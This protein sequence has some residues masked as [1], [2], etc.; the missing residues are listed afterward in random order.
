MRWLPMGLTLGLTAL[1]QAG[2]SP[3]PAEAPS[4]KLTPNVIEMGAFY[5]GKWTRIS[6]TVARGSQAIVVIR[7]PD[8]E[9]VFNRKARAGPIWI[10]SGRVHISGVPSLFLCYSSEPVDRL[11]QRDE[12]DENQLDDLAVKRQMSVTPKE[13]DHPVIRDNFVDLKI[14]E[15]VYRT[16]PGGLKMGAPEETG[17]PFSVDFHWPRKAP[18][19]RYQVRVY[20]CRDGVIVGKTSVRLDVVKIGF[21]KLMAYLATEHASSYG[22]VAVLLAVLGGLGIDFLAARLFRKR[23]LPPATALD[24][25]TQP[26]ETGKNRDAAPSARPKTV[27]R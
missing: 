22:V 9:E 12:I 14:K 27:G 11:L 24:R 20:E 7:G 15:N 4:V 1:L 10:N 2:P 6:G 19:D 16:I 3:A 26:K 5:S 23:R 13:M 8:T 25:P 21:P 17:V 18:P